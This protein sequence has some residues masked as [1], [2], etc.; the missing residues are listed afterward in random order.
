MNTQ[1]F[2][3]ILQ[4]P[5]QISAEQTEALYQLMEQ[6]P[7]LQCVRALHLKGLKNQ[8]S[9]KYNYALKKTA[10]YTTDR[11]ILFEYI[12][13]ED[14]LAKE[15]PQSNLEKALATISASP[16]DD[17]DIEHPTLNEKVLDPDLFETK[18]EPEVIATEE[19]KIEEKLNIGKPL[20]FEKDEKHSFNEWLQ[21]THAK[22][23]QRDT[24]QP[25]ENE[26]NEEPKEDVQEQTAAPTNSKFDL[27]DKFIAENPKI[28]PRKKVVSLKN[29]AK[30]NSINTD[31]LMTETLARVYL[32]QKNYKKAIQAYRILS[33]KNPE[34]S[35]FFADQISEIEKLE[36]INLK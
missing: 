26:T 9:Y 6:Y 19:E 15:V 28:K 30:E 24:P 14:F 35:S 7:Y 13:S 17:L 16:Y 20:S 5:Q 21:L 12:T 23:I 11:S 1:D 36:K 33:L 34:K 25:I 4:Q 29:L 32:E 8:D 2:H 22:P 31:E 3:N 18:A 10:A 27:I